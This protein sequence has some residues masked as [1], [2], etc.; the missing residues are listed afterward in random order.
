MAQ[1]RITDGKGVQFE[2]DN[3]V[4]VSIQI[5]R[6]N[7]GDNYNWPGGWENPTRKNPL[8]WSTKAEVAVWGRDGQW[9]DLNN[10]QVAGYVPV[11]DVLTFMEYL[12]C[13]P[14]NVSA[15]SVQIDASIL[16]R[17]L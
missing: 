11:Q 5:G 14:D 6:G 16:D 13:L 12:R 2:F 17:K 7:Y 9:F 8:P 4:T 1:M 10:D 15:K 3:G